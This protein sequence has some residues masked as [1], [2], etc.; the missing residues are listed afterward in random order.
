[1]AVMSNMNISHQQIVISKIGF[2]SS[3]LRPTV[4]RYSF[5]DDIFTANG[6]RSNL[7]MF[8]FSNNMSGQGGGIALARDL[9]F[10]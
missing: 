2:S 8:H 1:M 5:S 4:Y 7:E 10:P 9:V 3:S 6:G